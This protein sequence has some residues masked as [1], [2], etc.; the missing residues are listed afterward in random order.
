MASDGA[1]KAVATLY[2]TVHNEPVAVVTKFSD[3]FLRALLQTARKAVTAEEVKEPAGQSLFAALSD[4]LLAYLDKLKAGPHQHFDTWVVNRVLTVM[5]S[6]LQTQHRQL[7]ST[8][9]VLSALL[10]C[11]TF[12]ASRAN[13]KFEKLCMT[14]S[15]VLKEFDL[16]AACC[17]LELQ[18]Q[19]LQ[20]LD[21]ILQEQAGVFL[22]V[23]KNCPVADAN[24][25]V[26]MIY[27]FS[28]WIRW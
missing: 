16:S 15:G 1:Q 23:R 20:C 25:V 9:I 18:T 3:K 28:R 17:T 24:P 6:G 10:Q 4:V 11:S 8:P 7:F 2:Q 14:C 5:R 19:G 13:V 12:F 21:H 27:F 22:Q 26:G